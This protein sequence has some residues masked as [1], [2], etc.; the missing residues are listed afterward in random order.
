MY[1]AMT[2]S[3]G[4]PPWPIPPSWT[5]TPPSPARKTP[6]RTVVV[7]APDDIPGVTADVRRVPEP[8]A[9]FAG[10]YALAEAV[11]GA[12]DADG[13]VLACRMDAPEETAWALDLLHT[14]EA[15]L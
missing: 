2:R 8:E 7:L 3:P 13:V 12:E 11:A 15:P 5:L 14:G 10:V 1:A 4:P 9:G 6:G